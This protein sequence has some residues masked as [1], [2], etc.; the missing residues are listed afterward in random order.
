VLKRKRVFIG[1]AK[2]EELRSAMTARTADANEVISRLRA[3]SSEN[4]TSLVGSENVEDAPTFFFLG[5]NFLTPI[6]DNA[7]VKRENR[8]PP[9]T[10]AATLKS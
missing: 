9:T 2:E 6:T 10:T 8:K 1:V 5:S 4:P 7:V 3:R